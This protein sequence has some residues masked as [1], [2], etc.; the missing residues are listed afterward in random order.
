MS[1]VDSYSQIQHLAIP[2]TH[3]SAAFGIPSTIGENQDWSVALQL[4]KGIRFFD[5]RISDKEG[6]T[7]DFEL[8]HG[9]LMLGSF[10]ETIQNVTSFLDAH[11]QEVVFMSIKGE[12][13]PLDVARL[14]R[15]FIEAPDSKFYLHPVY[16]TTALFGLR[17]KIV[18]IR[19]YTS[20]KNIGIDWGN[21]QLRIQDEY[22][23]E[24]DCKHV[25]ITSFWTVKTCGAHV[26]L[27]YPKKAR[28]VVQ[29][30]DEAANNF[31]SGHIYINF[32]SAQY[33]GLFISKSAKVSNKA[34][35]RYFRDVHSQKVGSVVLMDY[36]NRTKGVI[37]AI[38]R[39]CLLNTSR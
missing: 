1:Q 39:N 11:P 32:A 24:F 25:R 29:H 21:P 10:N 7:D 31:G 38:I 27:N 19:R 20:S 4:K 16:P 26:G 9:V 2:G 35:K 13:D 14:E 37:D 28:L 3:N 22:D 6:I 18:L 33:K 15:D 36:P 34:V 17:G 12:N 8:R 30:L 5:I 23:L